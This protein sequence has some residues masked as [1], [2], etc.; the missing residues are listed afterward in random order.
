MNPRIRI[1]VGRQQGQE[2]EIPHQTEEGHVELGRAPFC[3][4]QLYDMQCSGRH[5]RFTF[6]GG[7]LFL[8]DLRSKNGTFV[9]GERITEKTELHDGDEIT[10]G[11][12]SMVVVGLEVAKEKHEQE[13]RRS[14]SDAA[15]KAS[16]AS[17]L[18]GEVMAGVTLEEAIYTGET[19]VVFK[20]HH[21]ESGEER[22]LKVLQPEA[23]VSPEKRNRFIRGHRYASECSTS[24]LVRA[25]EAGQDG[26]FTYAVLQFVHGRNLQKIIDE[27]S[28]TVAVKQAL[29]C[30]LELV[31]TLQAL[32]EDGMAHRAVR[33]DNLIVGKDH[34]P[35]LT[36]FEL[37]K[38][39]PEKGE[40]EVTRIADSGIH[41]G[42]NF[43][44]P[45]MLIHAVTADERADVF[46]AAGCLYFM[47][48][49]RAPFPDR[50]PKG[51]IRP[52]FNR[53]YQ[54]PSEINPKVNERVTHILATAMASQTGDRYESAEEM[55]DDL[56]EALAEM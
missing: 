6:D 33:P 39:L 9:N 37:V 46:G 5:C 42:P 2:F 22:A 40:R 31:R 54:N 53:R 26:P 29:E 28:K 23:D 7:T 55:A 11:S 38:P 20:G 13:R 27:A 24:G 3:A 52:I 44:P 1:K 16:T 17:Q 4:I 47:L 35:A 19:A 10:I 34:H 8:D 49:T 45:E 21:E 25:Y 12:S 43:A 41:V 51:G 48:T 32:H 18:A 15:E 36:D 56:E 14:T 30:T 50:V